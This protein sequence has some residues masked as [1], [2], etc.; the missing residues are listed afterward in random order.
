MKLSKRPLKDDVTG[1]IVLSYCTP[2]TVS[3]RIPVGLA[4]SDSAT[5]RESR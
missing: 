4:V 2:K 1:D 5:E 3:K